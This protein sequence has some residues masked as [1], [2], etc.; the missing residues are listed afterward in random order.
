[1]LAQLVDWD[2]SAVGHQREVFVTESDLLLLAE[3]LVAR[4]D[5][6]DCLEWG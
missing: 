4:L 3:Q 6:R 5:L 2:L 1:M